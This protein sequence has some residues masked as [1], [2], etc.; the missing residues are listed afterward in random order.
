MLHSNTQGN[1]K[2]NGDVIIQNILG[3]I[4]KSGAH[5]WGKFW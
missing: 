3:V 5:F 4:L 1:Y 2:L